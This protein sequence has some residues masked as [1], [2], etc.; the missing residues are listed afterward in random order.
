MKG[1]VSTELLIIVALVL[2]I[3]IPLLVLVYLKAGQASY[4]IGSYQAE[5]SVSRIASLANSVGSL[6]TETSVITD[7]YMPPNTI[8]F[9]TMDAG[10]RGGEL[11][12]SIQTD[13]GPTEVVEIIK[14]PLSNPGTIAD[15]S[16]AGGWIRIKISSV[17]Q[18]NSASLEIERL[19]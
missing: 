12:L 18:N 9:S 13:Q 6:G 14:F 11:S 10:T 4:E 5:L 16:Q 8:E 19:Q 15:S 17:F 3:F 2:L 1:Q 7:V